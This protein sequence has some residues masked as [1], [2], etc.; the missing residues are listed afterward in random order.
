MPRNVLLW[1]PAVHVYVYIAFCRLYYFYMS[2]IYG[3]YLVN[4]HFGNIPHSFI[5]HFTLHS[6]WNF[7]QIPLDNFPHSTIRIPQNT[8][9]FFKC[10]QQNED[11]AARCSF[12]LMHHEVAA[13]GR[14]SRFVQG[15]SE[16]V[17]LRTFNLRPGIVTGS[18][19]SWTMQGPASDCS[20]P[21]RGP[22]Y[23][24]AYCTQTSFR[25]CHSVLGCPHARSSWTVEIYR[26]ASSDLACECVKGALCIQDVRCTAHTSRLGHRC[27]PKTEGRAHHLCI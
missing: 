20:L 22:S 14:P 24:S 19:S 6:A 1:M 13:A 3:E 7:P 5:P 4:V 18:I 17:I 9:C 21:G 25:C 23:P 16:S 12:I 27:G 2:L 11:Q 15:P 8:C 26:L 10:Q